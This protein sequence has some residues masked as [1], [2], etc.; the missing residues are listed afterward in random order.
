M[1]TSVTP[2]I[3]DFFIRIDPF[4]KL[5]PA[6][7]KTLANSVKIKYLVKGETISFS[8]L[9]E[10][11][12][13]YIIRT[14]AIEQRTSGGE[15]RARLG[16]DDQFG[17]TFLEPLANTEDG[18]QAQ[19]IEDSLLY[20][21]PHSVLKQVSEAHPE[22]AD[23]FAAQA[24]VR[25]SSAVNFACLKEE[26]GLFFRKVGEIASE[27]ITIVEMDDS[28]RSVAQ[29][30]C[31]KQRSSCAV[32]MKDGDIVGLV[33]DRDMTRSVIAADKD[34]RAPISSVMTPNPILIE[35]DARVIHAIS[36]ML[37]YNIRCLP[38]VQGKQVK[39]LLTTTH[40]VHNHRTQSLFLIEKIKYTCSLNALAALREERQTIFQALVESGVSVEI[41]G[42]VMSMIMDAFTRRIIQLNEELLGPPPCDYAWLVAGSH[43]RNEVHMLSDQDSAI[44]IAD[45]MTED[46]RLYFLQL[47]M[48][49]CNGL[50][51]CGYPLCEG[52]Y[53]AASPRW[54]QP[55]H[56][57]KDY[58]TK[59]VASPEYN[60][61]LSISVFLEMRA[62]HGNRD[63]V[64]EI[65]Q[66]LHECIKKRPQFI[67]ALVRDAIETQPPL[68]IFN[69]L[70]LEKGGQNSNTLNI[71]KYALNLI[72]DLARIFS[73]KAGGSLTGTEERF[74]YAAQH[75]TLSKESAEN[76]IGAYRF[77]TQVR[78]RH[79]LNAIL[80]G[81]TPDNQIAPD[82]FS[83]FE[84][85]HLK[86]AFKIITELQD[87]AKLKFLKGA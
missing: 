14:G 77:I 51:A 22:F 34:T 50:A 18:Y 10:Q 70:V 75:G 31:G 78:F 5:P 86:D 52:K 43:A 54:C 48:R 62:I 7:V 53:M 72:I 37:Q 32:V 69:H 42:H 66:H 15:L 56:R 58:Y 68:G 11:R 13:L 59:W 61:L 80:S 55:V 76:I 2:N 39:G 87:I 26:K 67:P 49:V 9:C 27:N 41:Q 79:Q 1:G 84:R 20:L 57:W 44:V 81:N 21:V 63:L 83:S 73:L 82:E 64:D 30:M 74:R 23:H 35:D 16:Q 65:Q 25:L 40:L 8:A 36:L 71:K 17:F 24:N 60:K 12:Y 38:V 47:A 4:D 3:F 45:S 19:A 85:K 33:T 28:I 6:V 46:H 29:A